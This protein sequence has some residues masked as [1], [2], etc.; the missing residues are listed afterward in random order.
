MEQQ[1]LPTK[2]LINSII[3]KSMLLFLEK[4]G[5]DIGPV[6]KK[7]GQPREYFF[8]ETHWIDESAAIIASDEIYKFYGTYEIFKQMMLDA[9]HRSEYKVLDSALVL[10]LSPERAAALM[11]KMVNIFIDKTIVSKVISLRNG[12]LK[13]QV[14]RR[15]DVGSGFPAQFWSGLGNSQA[16]IEYF[17]CKN[18]VIRALECYLPIEKMGPLNGKIYSALSGGRIS[19]LDIDSGLSKIVGTKNTDGT[20]FLNG[21]LFGS[22]RIMLEISWDPVGRWRRL[23]FLIGGLRQMISMK[24]IVKQQELTIESDLADINVLSRQTKKMREQLAEISKKISGYHERISSQDAVTDEAY[25]KKYDELMEELNEVEGKGEAKK[26]DVGLLE[27]IKDKISDFKSRGNNPYVTEYTLKNIEVMQEQ[28]KKLHI[29]LE[30]KQAL[31]EE[32]K[33]ISSRIKNANELL[34]VMEPYI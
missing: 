5:H 1:T 34:K 26:E 15:G 3:V 6:L 28:S 22:S 12:Y 16:I 4:G 19:E 11:M 30:K 27:A 25:R 33:W 2:K 23:I 32:L 18:V 17:G 9:F 31:N 29:V 21:T 14:E 24:R 7:I 10:L 13:W 8:N 20:F